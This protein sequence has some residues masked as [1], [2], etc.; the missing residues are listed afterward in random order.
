VGKKERCQLLSCVVTFIHILNHTAKKDSSLAPP[1]SFESPQAPVVHSRPTDRVGRGNPTKS[2]ESLAP[3]RKRKHP[4]PSKTD[5]DPQPSKKRKPVTA[6]ASQPGGDLGSGSTHSHH[7]LNREDS[8]A[9]APPHPPLEEIEMWV[10]TPT[11]KFGPPKRKHAA[12]RARPTKE[13]RTNSIGSTGTSV[14]TQAPLTVSKQPMGLSESQI[15]AL[16]EEEEESQSQPPHRSVSRRSPK[17]GSPTHDAT[18]SDPLQTFTGDA[19]GE[20]GEKSQEVRDIHPTKQLSIVSQ[21]IDRNA[22]TSH[23]TNPPLQGVSE[24]LPS[25]TL[26]G[27]TR[28]SLVNPEVP[29]VI[30]P[31]TKSLLPEKQVPLPIANST[32]SPVSRLSFLNISRRGSGTLAVRDNHPTNQ[33]SIDSQPLDRN[34]STSH[35]TNPPLQGVS[36]NLP[37][38]TLPGPTRKSLVNPEVTAVI[39]PSTKSL[40]PEKQVPL[41]I[42]N[43]TPSPVSRFGF[44]NRS[45]RGSGT[46]AERRA[47]DARA[48]LD[49]VRRA[50]APTA[51]DSV[52]GR[53]SASIAPQITTP[54]PPHVVLQQ[55]LSGLESPSQS[56]AAVEKRRAP[57]SEP[58][59]AGPSVESEDRVTQDKSDQHVNLGAANLAPHDNEVMIHSTTP[60]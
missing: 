39:P 35:V 54:P 37:S 31:S 4:S 29:A 38:P 53:S 33:L 42:T 26:P 25:P 32:P 7:T 60:R 23:V 30:P 19:T 56:Q 28:K 8:P 21:P 24:N 59:E 40:L 15:I 2:S 14:R 6:I 36:E 10:P 50:A 5:D 47:F 12:A 46:L 51:G 45:Q 9:D 57:P 1:S 11:A 3:I 34:A 20:A 17:L 18:P 13:P 58:R 55:V 16:R 48:R 52:E 49:L 43:S 22:S 41:P 44:L 27:P